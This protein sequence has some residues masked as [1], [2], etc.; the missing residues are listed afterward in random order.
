MRPPTP[1]PGSL[2]VALVSNDPP[3]PSSPRKIFN[4]TSKKERWDLHAEAI[5]LS[6]TKADDGKAI[7]LRKNFECDRGEEDKSM[8]IPLIDVGVQCKMLGEGCVR[9]G[10]ARLRV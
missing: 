7:T 9:V 5:T 6:S 1:I 8:G 4:E 2:P 3:P 10:T